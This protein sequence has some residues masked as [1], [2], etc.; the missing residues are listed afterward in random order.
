LHYKGTWVIRVFRYFRCKD[1]KISCLYNEERMMRLPIFIRL[2]GIWEI[3]S[4]FAAGK[5]SKSVTNK[6]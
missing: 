4:I 2:G 5:I 1:S 3:S 6:G